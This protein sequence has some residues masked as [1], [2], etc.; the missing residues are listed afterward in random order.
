MLHKKMLRVAQKTMLCQ[1]KK[2]YYVELRYAPKL[3]KSQKNMLWK[4][5]K[6]C[7]TQKKDSFD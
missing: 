7:D 6:L 4:Q 2:I 1:P 5:K 3:C